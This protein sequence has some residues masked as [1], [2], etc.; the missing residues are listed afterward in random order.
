MM[1]KPRLWARSGAGR[2]CPAALTGI[3]GGHAGAHTCTSDG[4]SA[5]SGPGRPDAGGRR[6]RQQSALPLRR[7]WAP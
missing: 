3:N 6:M 5:M 4:H 7:R 1:I 2:T